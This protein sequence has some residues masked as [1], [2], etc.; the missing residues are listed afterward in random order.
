LGAGSTLATAEDIRLA[1]ALPDFD[2]DPF[3]SAAPDTSFRNILEGWVRRSGGV[4]NL[5]NSAHGWI[6]GNMNNF[7]TSPFEPAFWL[8]HANVD[9]IW[10]TWQAVHPRK[11]VQWPSATGVILPK[12]LTITTAGVGYTNGFYPNVSLSRITGAGSGAKAN[13]TIAGGAVTDATIVAGGSGYAAGDTLRA[14][15][16]DLGGGAPTTTMVLTVPASGTGDEIDFAFP[17][18]AARPANV[19]KLNEPMIPWDG[20]AGTRI[21]KPQDVLQWQKMGPAGEH[22]YRYSTDPPG[23]F[24]FT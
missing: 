11:S 12:P 1:V 5:H 22:Q 13:V 6:G 2:K 7:F 19:L 14:A 3:T 24:S 4:S 9:R 15:P 8:N 16:A 23:S 20:S 18:P 21:W 17:P 10:A